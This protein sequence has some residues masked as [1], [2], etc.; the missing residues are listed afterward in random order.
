LQD[1]QRGIT[2]SKNK[3]TEG[4]IQEILVE[5]PAR[6][7]NNYLTGRTLGNKVVNFSAKKDL[8]GRLVKVKIVKGFQNSLLG[9][10]VDG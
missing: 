10:L 1:T 2:L 7:G 9:E 4:S 8:K 5:G 6:R 3:L